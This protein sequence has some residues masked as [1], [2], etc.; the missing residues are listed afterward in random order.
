MLKIGALS[1]KN[2]LIMAPMAGIT[3]PPFRQIVRELGA[4][5]T[6]TE[7]VSAVGLSRGHQKTFHYLES[8]AREKPVAVQIFGADPVIMAAAAEKAVSKGADLVDI[9]M[10]C[11]ARK[12]I[13]NG[14]GGALLRS[15]SAIERM[16]TAVRKACTIPLTVKIRAGWSPEEAN[17]LEITDIL[18]DCGVDAVTVHPRFV[19]QGFS[20][21]ADWRI[22]REIK[23]RLTIP[24]IGNGDVSRPE[25]ALEMRKETGCDGVMI[26]RGALGNPWI[27]RQI[28]DLEKGIGAQPPDLFERKRIIRLHFSLL[29]RMMG[30]YV[31]AKMMRAQLLWYTKGLPHSSRFRGAFTG[32]KDINSMMTALNHYFDTLMESEKLS[33]DNA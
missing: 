26:G 19:K 15:P 28:L 4:G 11:P 1:L 30:E 29:S 10:G 14:S 27:F 18:E 6:V 13:K 20:G 32:I 8:V 9:N 16:V 31:A 7:M 12:V 2:R 22:I 21:R 17:F 33:G 25:M 5:L 3:N 24:V 23:K